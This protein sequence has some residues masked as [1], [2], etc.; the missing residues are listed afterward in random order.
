MK[1]IVLFL[2]AILIFS[3]FYINTTA[4]LPLS[5]HDVYL[6][7]IFD[8]EN[9]HIAMIFKDKPYGSKITFHQSFTAVEHH[10]FS[11]WI[12]NGEV[13]KDLPI[14]NEFVVTSH[15]HIQAVFSPAH[16]HVAIFIEPNG[17][18]LDVQFVFDGQ[19]VIFTGAYPMQTGMVIA[20][21]PWSGDLTN[22]EEDSVF[23]LQYESIEDQ[24][25]D[26]SV[27]GGLG[28]GTYPYGYE[29]SVI[30]DNPQPGYSFNYWKINQ[31][32]VSFDQ[33]MS[34]TVYEDSEVIAV[35]GQSP[36]FKKPIISISHPLNLPQP[37]GYMS[38]KGQLYVPDYY[39][40]I[41]FGMLISDIQTEMTIDNPLVTKVPYT[42]ELNTT[43]EFV[44]SFNQYVYTQ[45]TGYMIVK[46]TQNEHVIVYS[47]KAHEIESYHESFSTFIGS[48]SSYVSETFIGDSGVEWQAIGVRKSLA[49]YVIDDGGI[50]IRVPGTIT[51][52]IPNGFS[53]LSLDLIMA[54][55]GGTPEERTINIY[56]NNQLIG[57]HTL[58]TISEVETLI[59]D[60]F[61]FTSDVELTIEASGVNG[62]QITLNN[63]YW[64]TPEL[65]DSQYLLQV[66]SQENVLL[67][68]SKQGPLYQE[69]T[70]L[71]VTAGTHEELSFSHWINYLTGE[72]LS[73]SA[74]YEFEITENTI[75]KAIY[76]ESPLL[77]LGVVFDANISNQ[78]VSISQEGPYDMNEWVTL[79]AS[80]VPDYDFLYWKDLT[81]EHIFSRDSVVSFQVSKVHHL[82]AIY[83]SSS[84]L[85]YTTGFEDTSKSSYAMG[86]LFTSGQTWLSYQSLIGTL[87]QDSIIG[88]RSARLDNG[89]FIATQFPINNPSQLS[90]SFKTYGADPNST[91][92]VQF[93][94]NKLTWHDLFDMGSTTNVIHVTY[95][96]DLISLWQAYDIDESTEFYFR[97]VNVGLGTQTAAKIN[98]DNISMR[99]YNPFVGYPL[100]DYQSHLLTFDFDR[101]FEFVYQLGDSW[102][103]TVCAA[104]D[105]ILGDVDCEQIGFV[106]TSTRGTYTITYQAIDSNGTVVE[107][108]KEV[109]VIRD[110]S[111]LHVDLDL[112][113]HYYQSLNGL[114]GDELL[115]AMRELLWIDV[116]LPSYGEIRTILEI[117]DR[118]PSN[119]NNVIHIYTG[120]SVVG[121]WDSRQ[122]DREHIWPNSRLGILRVGNTSVNAGSDAHN[123]RPIN[124]SINSSR[125]NQFFGPSPFWYPDHQRVDSRSD[126]GDV[127]RAM[128]YMAAMYDWLNL[129]DDT[130][131]SSLTY[132]FNHTDMA[133]L[134]AL[135]TYH[136]LDLPDS[137]EMN[138]N[139]VIY[140][141]QNNRNPFV[142]YPHFVELIW[143]AHPSIPEVMA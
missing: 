31:K 90:F 3:T 65:T 139:Q 40:L 44:M 101:E 107:H 95:D 26:I 52:T 127:A 14:H 67:T 118:D 138:R 116:T 99:S 122:W 19:P 20:Q 81:T 78:H 121:N 102:T 43:L 57:T 92:R 131:Q 49:G 32:I 54:F 1:K 128:F 4:N 71:T 30:A 50:M 28:S 24:S 133:L 37:N 98:I 125:G 74:I 109:A 76:S 137:F 93:S 6:T 83:Q 143:F 104:F 140:F 130:S 124:A 34:F 88:G 56:A 41:E 47:Q 105:D 9:D 36:I 5:S 10:L 119:P 59:I 73:Y 66:I 39:E 46:N 115:L 29:V 94:T 132:S 117:T 114:Y 16:K 69:N 77:P 106:D 45:V 110:K 120:L 97:F 87:T 48:G 35:Y 51:G 63:L 8:E 134:S 111:L 23:V 136:Y 89:G 108:K 91:L 58:S 113:N 38:H 103:P 61:V 123:L 55:V 82:R 53:H 25:F 11:F 22:I 141:Y 2:I 42:S 112:Y 33:E 7:S 126:I 18:L 17:R 15:L 12:V 27:S 21:Q 60:N 100:K 68:V 135:I 142:D 72:I 13:R 64:I 85:A 62:R 80:V 129:T 96:L 84:V 75:L 86:N 79:S 70:S